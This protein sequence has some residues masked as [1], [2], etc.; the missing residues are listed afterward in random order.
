MEIQTFLKKKN[1]K[2]KK[3]SKLSR[4]ISFRPLHKNRKKQKT[5]KAKPHPHKNR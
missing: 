5:E 4:E 3:N 1:Q 2:E